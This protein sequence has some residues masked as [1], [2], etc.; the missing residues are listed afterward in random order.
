MQNNNKEAKT[1]NHVGSIVSHI[2]SGWKGI[3]GS[4]LNAFKAKKPLADS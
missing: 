3:Y 1:L 2:I 4:D